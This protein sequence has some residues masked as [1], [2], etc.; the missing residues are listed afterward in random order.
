MRIALI[1]PAHSHRH[2][3]DLK[4]PRELFLGSSASTCMPMVLTILDAL[5]PHEFDVAIIDEQVDVID[6]NVAYDLV[7]ITVLTPLATRA[8]EIADEFRARGVWVVLGGLHVTMLPEEA[9]KHTDTVCI[10]EAEGTWPD[11]LKDFLAKQPKPVYRAY[12]TVDLAKCVIPRWD[13]LRSRRYRF[14]S[15]QASRGCK[16]NCDYCSVRAVFGTPRYKP[17]PKMLR[18]IEEVR[19]HILPRSDRFLLVDDNLF[20]EVNYA[21]DFIRALI[22]LDLKWECFAPL[23]IAHDPEILSLLKQSGCERLSIGIESISQA[24][25]ASVNKGAVN[26]Y[27]EYRESIARIYDNGLQIVGLFVLGF[28][29]DDETIFERTAAFVQES[30]ITYPIFSILTPGPGTKLYARLEQEGRILH[31]KWEDY[32]GTRVVFKP[33]LM[34]PDTLQEGYHWLF[35]QVYG[36]HSQFERTIGLWEKGVLQRPVPERGMRLLLSALLLKEMGR[37]QFRRRDLLPFI[38]RTFSE[39][40]KRERIDMIPL[41]LN[42]GLTEY[43]NQL[44]VPVRDFHKAEPAPAP[45]ATIA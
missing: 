11:F 28:D 21:K 44:P 33:K 14:F 24:S 17:V 23:N 43:V 39:L 5:I 1:S 32:D 40:W 29:G 20:S 38:R 2:I 31:N 22:P 12:Q 6:F 30:M 36:Y 27:A 25:L 9:G 8:Y 19:K 42:L 41:L 45:A 4:Y 18:E 3:L 34:S 13:R 37:Q 16:Y 7:A 15:I 10:G 35:K 26:K